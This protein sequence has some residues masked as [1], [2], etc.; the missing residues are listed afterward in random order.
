MAAFYALPP[1]VPVRVEDRFETGDGGVLALRRVAG[2]I[3]RHVETSPENADA[4]LVAFHRAWPRIEALERY[5]AVGN[6]EF[7][8]RVALDLAE[9]FPALP[10]ARFGRGAARAAVGDWDAA[11]AGFLETLRLAPGNRRATSELYLALA[12]G[13]R[14]D[15]AATLAPGLGASADGRRLLALFAPRVAAGDSPGVARLV[16]A[17]GGLSRA[18]ST[19]DPAALA[20]AAR[21]CLDAFP[22]EPVPLAHAAEALR[23]AGDRSAALALADRVTRLA[24][25]HA[26]G[27][28][29]LGTLALEAGDRIEAERAALRARTADPDDPRAP[30]LQARVLRAD[31]RPSQ[32]ARLLESVRDRFPE[33]PRLTAQ[34][35][36]ALLEA[37]ES[38]RAAELLERETDRYPFDPTAWFNLARTREAAGRLA[39]AEAALRRALEAAPCFPEATEALALLLDRLGR[40]DQARDL[41]ERL[42]TDLPDSPFG[43]RGLGDLQL[44]RNLGEAARAYARVVEL[45]PDLPIAGTL[46][47]AALTESR[48]GRRGEALTLFERAVRTDPR[49]HEA[50]CGLGAALAADGNLAGAERAFS[51]AVRLDGRVPGYRRNLAAMQRARFRRNPLR[52]W[53]ALGDARREEREAARLADRGV[54]PT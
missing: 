19:G 34:L 15:E 17:L 33:E 7:A 41:L 47:I 5:L 10:A 43:W 32:A 4:R 42:V 44:S 25:G 24:P 30:E 29:L 2:A 48:A 51:E 31:G 18:R 14:F 54:P 36:G 45:R 9:E 40:S 3:T 16:A 53:R 13:G 8:E 21:D 35:A 12:L 23:D 27:W 28:L 22:D 50:W 46:Y 11:A 26:P 20:E 1:E 39:G 52:H 49:R 6:F 38:D 37:L